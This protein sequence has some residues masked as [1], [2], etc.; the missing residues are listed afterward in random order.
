MQS[1]SGVTC[2]GYRS[3]D[4]GKEHPTETHVR[5]AASKKTDNAEIIQNVAGAVDVN[6]LNNSCIYQRTFLL[7]LAEA[8]K[9]VVKLFACDSS[10]TGRGDLFCDEG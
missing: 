7:M 1:C 3:G 2:S 6:H 10:S 5:P 8:T 9:Y 4:L